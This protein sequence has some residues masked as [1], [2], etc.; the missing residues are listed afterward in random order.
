MGSASR[1]ALAAARASLGKILA[2]QTGAEL[3]NASAQ[4]D[5]SS[6]LLAA[7]ADSSTAHE[8]KTQLI[9][10]LFGSFSTDARSVLGAAI[11]QAWSNPAE[12]VDG[13]EELSIRSE[14]IT[15]PDR[16]DELLTAENTIDSNHELELGLGNKL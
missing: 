15:N 13:G 2:P 11:G 16:A 4:I 6:G 12:L 10:R 14:A 8:A 5:G 9:E 7:L 1:E 3:L